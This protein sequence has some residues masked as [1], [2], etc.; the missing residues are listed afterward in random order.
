MENK[1]T[2]FEAIIEIANSFNLNDIFDNEID[3]YMN[4][5]A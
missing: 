3:R 5:L 1:N 2:R 4:N